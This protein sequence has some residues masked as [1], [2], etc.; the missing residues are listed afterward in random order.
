M[1]LPVRPWFLAPPLRVAADPAAEVLTLHTIQTLEAYEQLMATGVLVGDPSR[2]DAEFQE[3]YAWM[4]EQMDRRGVPGAPGGMVWL[5]ALTSRRD[6]CRSA[7]R[8]RGDVLLTVRMAR[9]RVL[10]SDIADWCVVPNRYVHVPLR[11][12]ESEASWDERWEATDAEFTARSRPYTDLPMRQW[13]ADLREQIELSWEAIF[14][15]STWAPG[16]MLQATAR[17]LRAED[18]VGAVRIAR[19][20]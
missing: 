17:E 3:A 20:L 18:I 8:A 16:R 4:L 2:G 5:Y 1:R 6:L 9:G 13:P 7:R 19:T 12:G 11:P 14:D 10:I 15:P